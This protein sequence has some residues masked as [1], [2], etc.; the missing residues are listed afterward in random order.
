MSEAEVPAPSRGRVS[1]AKQEQGRRERRY[2]PGMDPEGTSFHLWVDE[3]K[4]D[5]ENFQYRWVSDVH[6]RIRRLEQRDW[7]V[8]SEAEVGFEIDRSG[9]IAPKAGGDNVRMRLMRKYKDW[10]E[11]D[12]SDKQRRIDEQMERAA[13]GEEIIQGKGQDTGPGLT[14]A[15]AYRPQGKNQ[16]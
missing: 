3:T 8:V 6:D 13:R 12:Q 4:L 5:R 10:F 14:A 15:N 7:D 16:L 2:Q 9:D 11:D 1:R